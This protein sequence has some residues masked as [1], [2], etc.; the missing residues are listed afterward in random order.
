MYYGVDLF[1]ALLIGVIYFAITLAVSLF[2]PLG[3]GFVVFSILRVKT[4][5]DGLRKVSFVFQIVL[6]I[7]S[8][9][10]AAIIGVIFLANT[11]WHNIYDS[12]FVGGFAI[13]LGAGFVFAMELIVIFWENS[14][15]GKR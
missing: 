3:I 7:I 12:G 15:L 9:L 11:Y 8:F 1:E 14:W 2:S 10:L 4:S 13:I 5:G 6:S